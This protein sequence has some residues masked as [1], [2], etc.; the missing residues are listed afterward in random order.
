MTWLR[1]PVYST[2]KLG[3]DHIIYIAL[4]FQ[5]SA[6]QQ[7]VVTEIASFRLPKFTK[8]GKELFKMSLVVNTFINKMNKCIWRS[9]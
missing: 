1:R 9:S 2:R 4:P 8:N 3:T 6:R 5:I 7:L